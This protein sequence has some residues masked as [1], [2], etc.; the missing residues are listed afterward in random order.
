MVGIGNSAEYFIYLLMN[1]GA[2]VEIDQMIFENC[3]L[4]R[5]AGFYLD[6]VVSKLTITNSQFNNIQ[7]GGDNSV[8]NTGTFSTLEMTN[9]TFN[10]I[11]NQLTS[12]EDN[13]MI[14]IKTIN[15][16]GSDNSV[17]SDITVDSAETGFLLINSI[18]GETT[19]PVQFDISKI[20]FQN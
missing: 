7:I 17:I 3:N 12:D 5:Q 10:K 8:I 16:N 9:L 6:A 4:G 15:L 13:Y 11:E 1:T 14:T 18:V 19:T 20:T 2:T